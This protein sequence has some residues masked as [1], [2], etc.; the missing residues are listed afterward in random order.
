MR[1]FQLDIGMPETLYPGGCISKKKFGVPVFDDMI[2][3]PYI[4]LQNLETFLQLPVTLI[5]TQRNIIVTVKEI[6]PAIIIDQSR[7]LKHS[8]LLGIHITYY[9]NDP[10]DYKVFVCVGGGGGNN[11]R[12]DTD[13]LR[14]WRQ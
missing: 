6:N 2:G 12:R 14:G 11:A 10:D 13:Y 9:F 1:S 5:H 8:T 3:Q 4:N 7:S